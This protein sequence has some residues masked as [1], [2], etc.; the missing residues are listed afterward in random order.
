MTYTLTCQG[1]TVTL[2][3][4]LTQRG[5]RH[6]AREHAIAGYDVTLREDG[7]FLLAFEAPDHGCGPCE[8]DDPG[9]YGTANDS[10]IGPEIYPA[11]DAEPW[12]RHRNDRGARDP[13]A[14]VEVHEEEERAYVRSLR[15]I[16]KAGAS[17][18][19]AAVLSLPAFAAEPCK[20]NVNTAS[21]QELQLLARTGP[22]L[23]LRLASGRPYKSLEAVDAVKGIGASWMAVNGPHVAFSGPTTCTEKIK[24]PKP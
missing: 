17:L 5:A 11:L 19:L 24:A 16:G 12:F 9:Y 18:L 1:E 21:P 20:V 7:R 15:N 8:I 14:A 10:E 23:S 2:P 13:Q 22:V 4:P 6:I 3:L